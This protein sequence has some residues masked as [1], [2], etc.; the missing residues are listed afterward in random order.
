LAHSIT[1]KGHRQLRHADKAAAVSGKLLLF[2]SAFPAIAT[3]DDMR[4]TAG[5]DEKEE[6]RQPV[7]GWGSFDPRYI[8]VCN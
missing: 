3:L 7:S 5:L 4:H 1:N 8:F 2:L 6:T